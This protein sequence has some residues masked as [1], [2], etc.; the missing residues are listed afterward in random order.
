MCKPENS[1]FIIAGY[2]IHSLSGQ[3]K[4]NACLHKEITPVI[5]KLMFYYINWCA[6]SNCY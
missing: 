4:S 6:I 5:S 1:K 2:S 3:N